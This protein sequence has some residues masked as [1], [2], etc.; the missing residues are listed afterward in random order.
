M[1]VKNN[2]AWNLRTM[3]NKTSEL[4]TE[5]GLDAISVVVNRPQL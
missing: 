3:C 2:V 4:R 5:K 1:E